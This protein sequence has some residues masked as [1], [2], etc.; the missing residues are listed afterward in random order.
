MAGLVVKAFTEWKVRG[1]I[2]RAQPI[3]R[4]LKLPR[5][6]GTPFALQAAEPSRGSDDHIKIVSLISPF[7]LNT[8]TIK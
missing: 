5:N 7:V 3:L 6:E 2:P 4:V 1:S 8:L